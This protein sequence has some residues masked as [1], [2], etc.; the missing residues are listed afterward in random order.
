MAAIHTFARQ[1]PTL[2]RFLLWAAFFVSQNFNALKFILT[3]FEGRR[4]FVEFL[5]SWDDLKKT[6]TSW[7]LDF[8]FGKRFM[9]FFS[10]GRFWCRK[11]KNSL[12]GFNFSEDDARFLPGN[13]TC[14]NEL[15]F[16]CI[17]KG[18]IRLIFLSV[19][20]LVAFLCNC[21]WKIAGIRTWD[22]WMWTMFLMTFWRYLN[23]PALALSM[24]N[25]NCES[26]LQLESSKKFF[27]PKLFFECDWQKKINPLNYSFAKNERHRKL[28][29]KWD[30]HFLLVGHLLRHY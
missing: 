14:W 3:V 17:E 15:A 29:L 25:F 16:D 11:W 26:A 12:L 21:W 9:I 6:M 27:Q 22:S 7:V 24:S 19:F 23:F 10:L 30:D 1:R 20:H 18:F 5:W 2:E 8:V 13:Y 4:R 28:F